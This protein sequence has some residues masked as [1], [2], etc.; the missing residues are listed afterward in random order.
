MS[1][2]PPWAV[3]DLA[4]RVDDLDRG[5]FDGVRHGKRG[6]RRKRALARPRTAHD[7]DVQWSVHE[8]NSLNRR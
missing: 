3:D 2:M 8:A 7:R 1:G 5:P 4:N 6:Q